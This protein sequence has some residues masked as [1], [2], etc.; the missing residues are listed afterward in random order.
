VK[1]IDVRKEMLNKS[2]A[3]NVDVRREMPASLVM[4]LNVTKNSGVPRN[5]VLR[6]IQQIQLR[7]ERTGIWGR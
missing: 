6:G 3:I 5:F 7:T 4:Y 1:C 2:L